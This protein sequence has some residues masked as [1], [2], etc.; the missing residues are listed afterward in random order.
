[1]MNAFSRYE[2]LIYFGWLL[3]SLTAALYC[4]FL[5]LIPW[6]VGGYGITSINLIF[7]LSILGTFGLFAQT[8]DSNS[9]SQILTLITLGSSIWFPMLITYFVFEERRV[10][11]AGLR[12]SPDIHKS[13]WICFAIYSIQIILWVRRLYLLRSSENDHMATTTRAVN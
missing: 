6:A 10:A 7:A 3:I 4:T 12:P 9:R 2:R 5:V 13:Y 11:R 8:I 1:M